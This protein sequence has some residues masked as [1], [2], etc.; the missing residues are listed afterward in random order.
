MKIPALRQRLATPLI[1]ALGLLLPGPAPHATEARQPRNAV[2]KWEAAGHLGAFRVITVPRA[3]QRKV[4]VYWNALRATC[5]QKAHCN[6][7]YVDPAALDEI[8]AL[9]E[10]AQQERALLIYTSNKGFEWNCT[11]RPD[12]DNCFSW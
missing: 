2:P 10:R 3:Q 5:K 11:I 8:R 12:A 1:L 9:P 6:L 7:M 4:A